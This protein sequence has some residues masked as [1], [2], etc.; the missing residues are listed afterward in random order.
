M[1]LA[2]GPGRG[3]GSQHGHDLVIDKHVAYIQ[4]LDTVRQTSRLGRCVR[5]LETRLTHASSVAMSWSII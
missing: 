2:A 1:S 3:G 5:T 4:K